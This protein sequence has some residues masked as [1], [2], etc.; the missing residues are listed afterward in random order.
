M[1][2]F[3]PSLSALNAFESSA[4]LL[5]F[6][7]AAEDL[8][9]TQSGVS[10]Q[11]K[12]LEDYL[13]I[14]LFERSGSRLI[15]TDIGRAYA[16]EVGGALD[17]L[18][19][20][21]LDVVRGRKAD[22]GLLIGCLPTLAS[23]WLSGQL[24]RYALQFPD[25]IYEI[26]YATNQVT[27]EDSSFD[28][29][30][31]RSD[32]PWT[33]AHSHLLFEERI[34]VVASPRLISPEER[35]D[36]MSFASYRLLQ[37]AARP[38]FWLQWLRAAGLEYRGVIQGPRFAHTGM[39]INAAVA[40]VGLAVVPVVLVEHELETGQLYM[41]FGDAVPSGDS[42]W[43]VYAHYKAHY[44]EIIQFRDWLL[45]ATRDRRRSVEGR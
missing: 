19:K 5:S 14:T 6:T 7:R 22:I 27:F 29:A 20:A 41:P 8:C 45:R 37:N 35:L 21:S 32:G 25:S 3:L 28:I 43:A 24:E 42:Y 39:L 16:V 18:E 17:A 30:L 36:P 44:S 23:R 26:A 33:D 2:R 11:I 34:A 10:R 38:S 1:R 13:G 12:A 31:L 15:L 4:R 9:I 40:G